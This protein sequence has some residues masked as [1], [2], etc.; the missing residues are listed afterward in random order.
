MFTRLLY[1]ITRLT[2]ESN[3]EHSHKGRCDQR[4]R[5]RAGCYMVEDLPLHKGSLATRCYAD[6][7]RNGPL[8][9]YDSLEYKG[10]VLIDV[11]QEVYIS[12]K[13]TSSI[14][15]VLLRLIVSRG[16]ALFCY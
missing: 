3:S 4:R 6:A 11:L 5:C 16:E 10:A 1:T 13:E 12:C 14:T 15:P 7:E 8:G 9:R 2:I